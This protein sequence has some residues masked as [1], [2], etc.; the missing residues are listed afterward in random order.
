M[1][2]DEYDNFAGDIGM[3]DLEEP[4]VSYQTLINIDPLLLAPQIETTEF[5]AHAE[6]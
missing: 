1:N 6:E 5:C 3:F 2:D 4:E